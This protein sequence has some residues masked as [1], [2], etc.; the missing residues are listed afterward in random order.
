MPDL[1]PRQELEIT[2]PSH[3]DNQLTIARERIA[4][5]EMEILSIWR[6]GAEND[7]ARIAKLEN[8]LKMAYGCTVYE[9]LICVQHQIVLERKKAKALGKKIHHTDR[10][11]WLGA[12]DAIRN[13]IEK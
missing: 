5:L 2:A 3:D 10:K 1:D 12:L 4:E 7:E 13:E 8:D 9:E 11:K 6:V